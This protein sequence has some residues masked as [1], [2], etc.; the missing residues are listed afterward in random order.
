MA[1]CGHWWDNKPSI[2][3]LIH[4]RRSQLLGYAA[5]LQQSHWTFMTDK[6]LEKIVSE[7][8][9]QVEKIPR[10]L[11]RTILHCGLITLAS[12][13]LGL[14]YF[15][16]V[17]LPPVTNADDEQGLRLY[18]GTIAGAV[19]TIAGLFVYIV[20]TIIRAKIKLSKADATLAAALKAKK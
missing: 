12:M 20:G 9:A 6:D 8:I 5:P 1:H 3:P 16:V 10:S 14:I 18:F 11:S 7:H 2:T 13:A 17:D 15:Q 19:I 4:S